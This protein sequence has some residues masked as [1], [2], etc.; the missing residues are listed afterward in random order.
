MRIKIPIQLVEL[1]DHNFHIALSSDFE[2][3]K[4]GTWVI[5]TGASKTVFDKN[6][7]DD[8]D[9]LGEED[10]IHSAGITDQPMISALAEMKPFKMGKLKVPG[11]KVAVIDLSHINALYRK[12][13]GP[14]ICG[15]IGSDFLIK[16]NA[17]IDYRRKIL[18]LIV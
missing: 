14:E 1:E 10:E 7:N 11:L 17:V 5:D 12:T 4:Q 9:L 13:G 15:L 2:D 8:Y 6:R 18:R 3:G 16:Y